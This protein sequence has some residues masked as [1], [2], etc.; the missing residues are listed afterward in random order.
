MSNTGALHEQYRLIVPIL[1]IEPRSNRNLRHPA[2][3]LYLIFPSLS[4]LSPQL[5]HVTKVALVQCL[6]KTRIFVR[7]ITL[8]SRYLHFFLSSYVK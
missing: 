3:Q 4:S 2:P 8:Y 1:G 6:A 7:L 5:P